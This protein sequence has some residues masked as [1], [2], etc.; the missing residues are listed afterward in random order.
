M[1]RGKVVFPLVM[2]GCESW[3]IKKAEHR[4]IDA[5]D[6]PSQ[7]AWNP[8]TLICATA[9]RPGRERSRDFPEPPATGGA[10]IM[11]EGCP[12]LLPFA[13]SSR[14]LGMGVVLGIH[15]DTETKHHT[16]ANKFQ[17]VFLA[18]P[19]GSAGKES[20]CN[21]GELGLKSGLG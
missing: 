16:G 9:R 2:Y 19:C 5:F 10:A 18:S 3:T 11:P 12:G 17:P 4:R 6:F 21:V 1:V 14:R 8:I 13:G 15:T 7:I 20:T